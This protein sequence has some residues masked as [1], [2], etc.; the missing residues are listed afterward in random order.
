MT[1][2]QRGR[3]REYR[4]AIGPPL[5]CEIGP[6][7]ALA[8]LRRGTTVLRALREEPQRLQGLR[9]ALLCATPSLRRRPQDRTTARSPPPRCCWAILRAM[10][11]RQARYRD[12]N[13]RSDRRTPRAAAGR[14]VRLGSGSSR[15]FTGDQSLSAD[16]RARKDSLGLC[17]SV[18]V[19]THG[20]PA[21]RLGFL[22][23]RKRSNGKRHSD[24]AR[25]AHRVA[26]QHGIFRATTRG[27]ADRNPFAIRPAGDLNGKITD[28]PP[29]FQ[30]FPDGRLLLARQLSS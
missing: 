27:H 29:R 6:Q 8:A 19:S 4:H 5:C 13:I 28:I 16:I 7:S 23:I 9:S 25:N 17:A 3:R 2:F 12:W 30:R 21:L 20:G 1:K 18:P 15:D 10:C 14:A 26:L 22:D 11:R 24:S